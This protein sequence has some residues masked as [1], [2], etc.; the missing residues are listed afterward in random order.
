MI[1]SV[2][3]NYKH[4]K[5]QETFWL[6]FV[7]IAYKYIIDYVFDNGM[8]VFSGAGNLAYD[9]TRIFVSWLLYIVQTL[10][11]ASAVSERS[12]VSAILYM[13][14]FCVNGVGFYSMFGRMTTHQDG[15][16]VLVNLFWLVFTLCIH[17][18]FSTSKKKIYDSRAKSQNALLNTTK[19]KL[20]KAITIKKSEFLLFAFVALA[21]VWLSGKY[22]GFRIITSFDDVYQYRMDLDMPTLVGYAFRFVSG[23]FLPYF[24]VRFVT[25]KRYFLAVITLVFAVLLFS[26]DGLKTNLVLYAV[27]LVFHFVINLNIGPKGKP[28]TRIASILILG[29]SVFLIMNLIGYKLSGKYLFLNEMYRVLI[30]PP[31]IA[32]RYY[33]FI[34]PQEALLLRESIMRAF[35]ESPY[36]RSISYLVSTTVTEY[37]EAVA[38]TGMFGDAYANFKI[39]GVIV[40]PIIYT[41]ILKQWEK[42]NKNHVDS[43][44]LSI[45]FIMI[46][47]AINI[48][49]FTWLL[50]GGVLVYFI[51][52]VLFISKDRN[53]EQL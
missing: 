13:L 27:V 29:I 37:G 28:V 46:W 11:I 43:F 36:D 15:C 8:H 23:V 1:K 21:S 39:F 9:Y 41:F 12:N 3:N 49:F 10:L 45:G 19:T 33:N 20:F 30:I 51:I 18:G 40:Y 5:S 17:F 22:G 14:L 6:W 53:R 50:T 25:N 2:V 31:N 47:N 38:N 35:F 52:T 34:Q 26:I 7:L 48:S 42:I 4:S 44:S 16:F 24:F 32:A